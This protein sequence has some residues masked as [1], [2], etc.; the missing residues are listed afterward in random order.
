M[1]CPKCGTNLPDTAKFCDKCGT[2]VT[3]AVTPEKAWAAPAQSVAP[4]EAVAAP[5]A[6]APAEAVAKAPKAANTKRNVIILVLALVVL[7]VGAAAAVFAIGSEN[8]ASATDILK[9]AERYL[10]E[11]N[12]EQAIIEFD[13][14][15]EIDPANISAYIGK[16]N[17]L[18][19]AGDISKAIEV[20]NEGY[21][22]T[23]SN[24][25]LTRLNELKAM[26]A[27]VDDV[28]VQHKADFTY[29]APRCLEIEQM[30]LSCINGGV[31]DTDMLAE[32]TELYLYSD[33]Y[34]S[35]ICG[36]KGGTDLSDMGSY[37]SQGGVDNIDFAKH[38][39]N[40]LRIEIVGSRLKDLTPLS[41]LT[42]LKRLSLFGSYTIADI[43][44]I[45]TLTGL[46]HLDLGAAAVSDITPLAKLTGLQSLDLNGNLIS[47]ISAVAGLTE[48]TYLDLGGNEISDIAAVK[49]LTKLTYLNLS[50][51]SITDITALSELTELKQL[52][53]WDNS[54]SQLGA[55][56]WLTKLE[57]LYLE[58]NEITDIS[59]LETLKNLQWLYL[60]GN[61]ID[62][63]KIDALEAA[64]PDCRI[65]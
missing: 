44:P 18:V 49:G 5:A 23:G 16:A 41:G 17:A 14:V 3:K 2:D 55:V 37:T 50:I 22:K 42:S 10:S 35:V 9:T 36:N 24:E 62:D 20:L 11:A 8:G 32:V 15:L 26:L 59:Q 33:C 51:N 12:Y 47:D 28:T 6:E 57:R 34:I 45:A 64:L 4:A 31:A 56:A 1:T 65:M 43:E 27:D 53:L 21:S 54:I 58:Y 60:I 48:L 38:L 25:I 30:L 40:A 39:V 29:G 19:N 61:D 13:K 63:S 7:L 46:T 52:Y